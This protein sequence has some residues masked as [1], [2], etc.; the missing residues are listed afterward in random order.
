MSALSNVQIASIA[1]LHYHT[2]DYFAGCFCTDT[3][4]VK[5]AKYLS[6]V[7]CNTAAS[8]T[9]GEHWIS[10]CFLGRQRKVDYFDS[11]GEDITTYHPSLLRF[12]ERN[13]NGDYN[14]NPHKYQSEQ[15]SVCGHYTL[16]FS[17]MRC[18]NVSFENCFQ[19]LDLSLIHI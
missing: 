1:R 17:D 8:Y 11:M 5:V 7:I 19:A 10:L 16:F 9:G 14:Y 18:K 4:P 13:S 15:S 2:K 3:L 12:I 6:F